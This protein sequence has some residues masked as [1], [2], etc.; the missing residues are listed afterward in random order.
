MSKNVALTLLPF[1]ATMLQKNVEALEATVN[2]VKRIVRRVVF[3]NV[4]LTLSLVR[5]GFR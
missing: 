3:D 5:M 1:L 4:V 2:F